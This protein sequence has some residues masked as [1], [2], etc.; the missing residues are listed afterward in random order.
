MMAARAIPLNWLLTLEERQRLPDAAGG[1]DDSWIAL[2]QLWGDVRARSVSGGGVEGGISSRVRYRITLRAAPE[3]S[4]MRPRIGQRLRH[5]TRAFAIEGV[6]ER[7]A[8]GIYLL[9]WAREEVLA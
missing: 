9:V 8:K 1:F 3:G 4:A 7:D 2:G 6:S 5:G